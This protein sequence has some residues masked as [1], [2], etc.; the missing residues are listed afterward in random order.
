L[1]RASLIDVYI[2][3]LNLATVAIVSSG[4]RC[5]ITEGEPAPG[6]TVKHRFY[7]KPSHAEL[8]LATIDLEGVTDQA[9]AAVAALIERTAAQP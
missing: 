9:P 1:S 2:S 4:R 8:L 3:G 7:F 6:E 5:R